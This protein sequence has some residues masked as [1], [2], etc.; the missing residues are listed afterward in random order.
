MLWQSR[1]VFTINCRNCTNNDLLAHTNG[2]VLKTTNGV[3]ADDINVRK[4][5]NKI[6][7]I[8]S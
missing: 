3:V 2:N 4:T 1:I 6:F 7:F 8:C 5:F